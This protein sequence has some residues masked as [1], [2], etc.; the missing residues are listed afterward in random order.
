MTGSRRS[1]ARASRTPASSPH[2]PAATCSSAAPASRPRA[3]SASSSRPASSRPP[4]RAISRGWRSCWPTTSSSAATA[5]ARRPPPR[6]RSTAAPGCA[7]ADR[8]AARPRPLRRLHRALDLARRIESS[9]RAQRL[10]DCPPASECEAPDASAS[11][12]ALAPLDLRFGRLVELHRPGLDVTRS[13]VGVDHDAGTRDLAVDKLQRGGDRAVAEEALPGAEHHR[14]DPQPVLVD[15]VMLEQ[16]LDKARA[17]MDLNLWAV[18]A[19]EFCDVF[20]DVA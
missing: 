19:L 2:A 20:R 1:S 9:P 7:L 17:A 11:R 14:E 8:G 6:A 15:E 3:R 4:K 16:R 10:A 18:P 13:F 5:A 12:E